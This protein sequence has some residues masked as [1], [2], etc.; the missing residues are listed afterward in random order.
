[1]RHASIKETL[2]S[3]LFKEPAIGSLLGYFS[4]LLLRFHRIVNQTVASM[5]ANRARQVSRFGLRRFVDPRARD[6]NVRTGCSR[7]IVRSALIGLMVA[8]WSSPVF[9]RTEGPVARDHRVGR[10]QQVAR[11]HCGPDRFVRWDRG[12]IVASAMPARADR[13]VQ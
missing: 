10:M 7:L 3:P 9:T 6:G 8:S 1:M 11:L 13:R 12:W 4:I 2:M 5:L